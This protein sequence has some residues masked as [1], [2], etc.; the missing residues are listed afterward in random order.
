VAQLAPDAPIPRELVPM[1]RTASRD[2]V[3]TDDGGETE[4]QS[5]PEA[6]LPIIYIF[7]LAHRE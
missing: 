5:A 7:R 6:K 2:I 3:L 4:V 1:A